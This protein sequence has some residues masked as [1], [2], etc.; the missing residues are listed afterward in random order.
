AAIASGGRFAGSADIPMM[1]RCIVGA[2]PDRATNRNK[3]MAILSNLELIRR[4]PLFSTLTQAQ[5]ELVAEAVIKRRF[6]RGE[7]IVEQGKKSNFLAIVLTGRARVVTQDGRGREVI[8][9]TLNPG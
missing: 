2:E 9:A 4:V 8:L 3:R 1:T 6:K 5:A 7:T